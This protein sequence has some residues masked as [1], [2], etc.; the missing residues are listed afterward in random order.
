MQHNTIANQPSQNL[1]KVKGPEFNDRDL[2][3]DALGTEKYLTDSF[4]VFAR[5]ASH[6]ALHQDVSGMLMESHQCAR[7]LFNLMF[8]KGWYKLEAED[9]QKLQQLGQQFSNYQTQFPFPQG[10]MQ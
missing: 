1:P 3:N 10:M 9:P 4:N 6:K 5:E 2:L 8:R 7:E